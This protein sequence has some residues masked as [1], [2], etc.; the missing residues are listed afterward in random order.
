[1]LQSYERSTGSRVC[2]KELLRKKL[3]A[4][5]MCAISLGLG[6]SYGQTT[7][8]AADPAQTSKHCDGVVP[9]QKSTDSDAAASGSEATKDHLKLSVGASKSEEAPEAQGQFCKRERP[10]PTTLQTAVAAA[11]SDDAAQTSKPDA[12]QASKPD[13]TQPSKS[14]PAPPIAELKDGKL[15]I[16]ANGEELASVLAAVQSVTGIPIEIPPASDSDR[17][18]MTLGPTPVKDALVAIVGGSKYNYIIMGSPDDSALVKRVI[19]TAR[20]SS[21]AEPLVASA[22]AS[23]PLAEPQ[24]YGGQGVRPDPDAEE[25]ALV[26]VVANAPRPPADI[27][28]SV[29]VGVNIQQMATQENKTPGQILDELQKRQ[30]EVLDQQVA[31]QQQQQPQ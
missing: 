10:A 30:L 15:S 20:S 3:P 7:S 11:Q 2:E 19:L 26:P 18:F 13:A 8:T 14:N 31:A 16:Q 21:D 25:E 22:P 4:L 29:P 23:Q 17:I 24:L 9:G 5:A 28:S 12:A 1:M 6:T 27:P